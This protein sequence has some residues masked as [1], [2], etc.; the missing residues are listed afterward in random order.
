MV[1]WTYPDESQGHGTES[2]LVGFYE[3][4]MGNLEPS[5]RSPGSDRST[6]DSMSF[7]GFAR[8]HGSGNPEPRA[9]LI[10]QYMLVVRASFVGALVLTEPTR[11]IRG[12]EKA[13]SGT[14]H[15]S[16]RQS[17]ANGLTGLLP[18]D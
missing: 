8:N 17:L 15:P 12:I 16:R 13:L 2:N 11:S 4:I 3:E 5:D 7:E 10:T 9:D 1:E 18:E 6:L 14:G